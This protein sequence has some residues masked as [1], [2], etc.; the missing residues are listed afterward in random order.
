M[1][2]AWPLCTS[3]NVY[4]KQKHCQQNG[5]LPEIEPPDFPAP[6]TLTERPSICPGS[7]YHWLRMLDNAH[8]ALELA[9]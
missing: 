8:N 1:S 2:L 6:P 4:V 5:D 3:T 9:A 7:E